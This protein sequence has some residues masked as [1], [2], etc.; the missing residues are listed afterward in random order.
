[1]PKIR[2]YL[3]KE[4]MKDEKILLNIDQRHYL[5]NVMRK[6]S[7]DFIY[8][9]NDLVEWKCKIN[10]SENDEIIPYEFV[11]KKNKIEDIWI[12]FSL[13][14]KSNIK[15]LIQKVTEIGVTRIIPLITEHSE[16]FSLT[17][18]KLKKISTEATE[19]CNSL[20]V[21]KISEIQLLENLL[22]KWEKDRLIF[23]CD[24]TGGE[25]ILKFKFKLNRHKKIAIFI[26]PIG[27]WSKIDKKNFTK[28]NVIKINFGLNILKA[29]TAAIYAL[30]CL[31]A[32]MR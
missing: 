5:K 25:N 29:D 24:E 11:R 16:K 6:E 12:C 8:V 9:F 15:N 2:I 14:K 23:F 19:Q 3:E 21:P 10:F 1:M 22:D 31:K 28:Q 27:G 4:I 7:G 20:H 26:G 18:E 17:T 30:S 32:M 13:I